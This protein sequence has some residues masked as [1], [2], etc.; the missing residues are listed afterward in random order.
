MA[1]SFSGG[2]SRRDPR[3]MDKQL[4]NLSLVVECTFL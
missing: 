3:T 1:I 4:V 2:G